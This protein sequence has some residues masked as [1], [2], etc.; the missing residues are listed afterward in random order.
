MSARGIGFGADDNEVTLLFAD[1]A[2]HAIAR[3]PEAGD[4]R[5][6]CGACSLGAPARR[7][8]ARRCLI[9]GSRPTRRKRCATWRR[10]GTCS[11]RDRRRPRDGAGT[12][13]PW[14]GSDDVD[15]HGTLAAI[16]IWARHQ[17]LSGANRY[18]GARSAAWTFVETNAKRFIP[19]AHRQRRR[20]RDRVR[21]RDGPDG[22]ARPSGAWAAPTAKR[23]AIADRAAR[24]LANHLGALEILGGREFSDPGFLALRARRVRARRRRSGPA[25]RRA[26]VR[27][28]RFRHEGADDVRGRAGG[29]AAACSISRRRRRRGSWRSSRRK[30][31]RRSSA[32]GCASGSRRACRPGSLPRRLDENTWNACAAW[33]LGRAYV[34]STDPVFMQAYSDTMDE[35]E[36]RDSRPRRRAAARQDG[37]RARDGGDVLLRAGGRRAGDGRERERGADRGR[38]VAW[39][40]DDDV[41]ELR[42]LV[43]QLRTHLETR[44]RSGLQGVAMTKTNTK[45]TSPAVLAPPPTAPRRRSRARSS[46]SRARAS[47]ASP[48]T[49]ARSRRRSAKTG[50][51]GLQVR[52]RRAGRL[53]ALQARAVA[54]RT[55]SSASATR[56]PIWCSSARRRA[57]TKT[58]RASR[59]WARRAS[60]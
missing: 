36:R 48:T 44:G 55:W 59:S 51:A 41:E 15:F 27:R 4:R 47:P 32:P 23:Q 6:A 33:A 12:C 16:W 26:Q 40:A 21:L 29:G 45:T 28:P 38:S 5:P 60:C 7:Q 57:R 39:P 25:G 19:D 31:R 46:P 56:T 22:A 30:G 58:R 35:L 52:A 14:P 53:P 43:G 24:V 18:Q 1:G 42:A 3:A 2:R 34:V 49:P 20:R 11:P 10:P 13:P 37:A 9:R 8:E 17:R 54:H 50:Q